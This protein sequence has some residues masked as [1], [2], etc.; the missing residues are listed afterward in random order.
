MTQLPQLL[1]ELQIV[2]SAGF[3]GLGRQQ[4]EH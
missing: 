2:A 1:H 4:S 3:Q